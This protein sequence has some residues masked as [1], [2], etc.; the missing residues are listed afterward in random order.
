MPSNPAKKCLD[1]ILDKARNGLAPK[2]N[3]IQFLL[4][5][6]DRE[7]IEKLFW[8]ARNVRRDHFG[9]AVFLY[10]FI[11]F[12][13]QCRNDCL[14]CR[15]RRTNATIRRYRK[16]TAEVLSAVHALTEAGVHLVDLTMGEAPEFY[17]NGPSGFEVLTELVRQ[18]KTFS[19]LPVMVSPGLVPEPVL[20][21]LMQ[22]GADWYACYQETHN[23]QLFQRLRVGQDFDKRMQIKRV[24]REV[25][26]LIEEGILTGVGESSKDLV[27]S[28]LAMDWLHADQVRVM[29][30]VP[31]QGT[32]MA[33]FSQSLV[34]SEL[35]IIAVLRLVFQDRLI[36]ASL[37]VGGLA[38]L[39]QRLSAGANVI[40]SLINP[41]SGLSGVANE[42]LDIR[43]A[44]RTPQA[45][46]SVVETCGLTR[47]SLEEY[48]TWVRRRS[49]QK[50]GSE[51]ALRITA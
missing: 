40:T 12:A 24:A 20:N 43:E 7:D 38:G 3:E 22:A 10:G 5:L 33:G 49:G 27:D 44:R 32:P 47:A 26:L 1:D 25:G 6:K 46:L 34:V 30:F 14:F 15:F 21:D 29:T 48:K 42:R 41:E 35:V 31:Q 16:T 28:I 8:A 23:R 2:E 4:S 51:P 18:I 50:T 11:Y 45:A 9:D 17:D 13:T 36:P 19:G 39:R 37:D